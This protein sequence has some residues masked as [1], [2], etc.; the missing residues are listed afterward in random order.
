MAVQKMK[1][2]FL[3][4]PET[5]GRWDLNMTKQ[6]RGKE[7]EGMGGREVVSGRTAHFRKNSMSGPSLIAV[8]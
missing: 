5:Q 3:R 8:Y 7:E 6:K 4:E 1:R 2:L